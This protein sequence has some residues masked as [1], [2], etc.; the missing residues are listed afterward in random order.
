L[1]IGLPVYNGESFIAGSVEALLG[2]T[3]EDFELIISDN[4][5]TD[6]TMDICRVYEKQDSRIRLVR[7]PRNLGLTPNHNFTLN[8]ARG[9]LFKWASHDDLYGRDLLKLCI[10]ALDKYPEVVL[11]HSWTAAIDESGAVTRTSKYPLATAA[12][13]APKRFRSVLFDAGG[14]DDGGVIRTE[15]LRRISPKD[16]YHHA[17]RLTIIELTLHGPFYHVPQW[18]YFRRIF[19]NAAEHKHNAMRHRCANMDPRRADP[20]RNPIVRLYAE[21]VWGY[22][23]AIRRSPLST[24]ERRECYRDLMSYIASRSPIGHRPELQQSDEIDPTVSVNYLVA[25]QEKT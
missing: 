13:L 11:S 24:A 7:Q 15:V 9:E 23:K 8:E 10:E 19:P 1:T 5:S 14:D 16:S 2:Q 4:A 20:V 22:I 18:L 25:G 17:D 21:Y 6:N 3:F 12:P